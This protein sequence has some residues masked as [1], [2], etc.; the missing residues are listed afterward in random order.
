MSVTA[1]LSPPPAEA[2]DVVV[3]NV[4]PGRRIEQLTLI[5]TQ[6][7]RHSAASLVPVSAT[8]GGATTRPIFGIG[9][10]GG[11][12]SGIKPRLTL[13]WNIARSGP[14]RTSRRVEARVPIPAPSAYLAT[15]KRWRVEVS[16]TEI[17]G[18]IRTLGFP[19]ASP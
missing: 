4:P 18:E 15:S 8:E 17:D 12:S 19:I 7:I 10:S 16:F 9:A 11:S 1:R 2:V 3:A 13:G 5:D 6:G 14:S